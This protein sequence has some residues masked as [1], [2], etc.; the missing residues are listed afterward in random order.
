MDSTHLPPF[1]K[2][3]DVLVRGGVCDL[4]LSL[5]EALDVL[6]SEEPD[7]QLLPLFQVRWDVPLS[8]P[9]VNRS[10]RGRRLEDVR[11]SGGFL[12]WVGRGFLTPSGLR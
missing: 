6:V 7:R 9:V 4:L 11:R 1:Y 3:G 12:D 5:G 10:R 8:V 2:E